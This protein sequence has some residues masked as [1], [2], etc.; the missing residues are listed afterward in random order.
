MRSIRALCAAVLVVTVVTFGSAG[1]MSDGVYDYARQHC[2]GAADNYTNPE[3]EAGC[4][5]LIMTVSD[6]SG[7]EYVGAGFRQTAEGEF[8]NTADI[9]IDLGNGSKLTWTIAGPSVSGPVESA[10]TPAEPGTGLRYYFGADDNLDAGEHDSSPQVNNGPSDGGA[11]QVNLNPETVGPWVDAL[12][13]MDPQYLL[14]HLL[15]L[16]D[17]GSGFCADNICMAVSTMRRVAF[18]GGD[19]TKSRAVGNYEGKEWDPHSCAGPS[20]LPEDC[21]GVPLSAW[22]DMEGTVYIEPGIQIFGDPDAQASPIGPYPLPVLYIGPCG[23][24]VGGGPV[25]FRP[26]PITNSAGQLVVATAC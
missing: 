2:S 6:Y 24:I 16:V 26:S 21:G 15:P 3:P 11:I 19:E 13:A 25:T 5:T 1:A 18:V 7:H 14:T 12:Q 8:V 22:N 23:I 9:W 10:G 17:A 20:D 4:Y